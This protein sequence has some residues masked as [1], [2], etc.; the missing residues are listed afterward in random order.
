M[1]FGIQIISGCKNDGK[2]RLWEKLS[3][4]FV[5]KTVVVVTYSSVL[6]FTAALLCPS[7]RGLLEP[8]EFENRFLIVTVGMKKN[9]LTQGDLVRANS[10]PEQSQIIHESRS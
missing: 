4:N 3:R 1:E 7:Q 9:L 8:Q 6:L 10:G 2:I 5:K